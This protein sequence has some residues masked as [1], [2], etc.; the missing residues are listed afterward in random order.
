MEAGVL[1]PRKPVSLQP[2]LANI[3]LY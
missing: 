2:I 1:S 3:R